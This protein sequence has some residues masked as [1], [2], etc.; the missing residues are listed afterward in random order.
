MTMKASANRWKSLTLPP[1]REPS[2]THSMVRLAIRA[3]NAI[4]AMRWRGVSGTDAAI[5]EVIAAPLP[6]R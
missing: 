2:A 3:M 5:S 6:S 4:D 1:R